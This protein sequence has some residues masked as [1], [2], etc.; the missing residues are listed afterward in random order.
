MGNNNNN[1][2]ANDGGRQES[3]SNSSKRK[4]N[5]R[6][7]DLTEF[8]KKNSRNRTPK[9]G[10]AHSGNSEKHSADKSANHNQSSVGSEEMELE[11]SQYRQ[12]IDSLEGQLKEKDKII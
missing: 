4:M 3:L 5:Q 8:F 9:K 10:N 11:Y 1:P 6:Q 12:I 7:G 2:S